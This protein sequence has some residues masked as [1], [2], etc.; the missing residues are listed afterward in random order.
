MCSIRFDQAF[1]IFKVAVI[2]VVL[3]SF[4]DEE[5]ELFCFVFPV[6]PSSP[7]FGNCDDSIWHRKGG[8]SSGFLDYSGV[9]V[10][11]CVCALSIPVGPRNIS[12]NVRGRIVFVIVG[13]S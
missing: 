9:D 4:L 13:L 6:V 1:I 2:S 10:E 12:G 8:D 11:Y 7:V 5:F 3:L